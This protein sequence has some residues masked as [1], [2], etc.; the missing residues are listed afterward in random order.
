MSWGMSQYL[1]EDRC[2][3]SRLDLGDEE[4]LG[5]DYLRLRPLVPTLGLE[6]GLMRM[7]EVPVEWE[8]RALLSHGLAPQE[9]CGVSPGEVSTRTYGSVPDAGGE[10]VQRLQLLMPVL[11]RRIEAHDGVRLHQAELRVDVGLLLLVRERVPAH[12]PPVVS[13]RSFLL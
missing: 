7:D 9:P 5:Q 12:S 3:V 4:Y 11:C 8:E 1:T 13:S 2:Y 10:N 6:Q